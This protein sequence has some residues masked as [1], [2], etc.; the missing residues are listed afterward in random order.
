MQVYHGGKFSN[1]SISFKGFKDHAGFGVF[2][3]GYR[4][5]AIAG[6]TT[7]FNHSYSSDVYLEG[8]KLYIGETANDGDYVE[9]EVVDIDNILGYG[10]N[11]V[12]SKMAETKYVKPNQEYLRISD[13]IKTVPQGFYMRLKYISTGTQNVILYLDHLLRLD[14]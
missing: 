8:I 13:A 14:E 11:F 3:K 12:V 4:C 1:M 7:I 5:V 2:E 6:Q 9:F 10:A